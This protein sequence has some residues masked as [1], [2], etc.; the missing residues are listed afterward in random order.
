VWFKGAHGALDIV[1]AAVL[2]AV[3]NLLPAGL[4][5]AADES[6][7]LGMPGATVSGAL[8]HVGADLLSWP[9]GLLAAFL[10]VHGVVKCL[11]AFCLLRRAVRAYPWAIAALGALLVYQVVDAAVSA[12]ITMAA[13]A[14]LDAAVIALVVGEYRQLR[15]DVVR[16]ARA[17]AAQPSQRDRAVL[18][19]G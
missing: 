16:R 18:E 15:A 17:A 2:L 8:R 19:A 6:G 13:L 4:L 12:S 7:D 14:V 9:A 11:S 3:P 5:W 1:T 10:L